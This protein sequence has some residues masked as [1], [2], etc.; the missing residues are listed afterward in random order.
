MKRLGLMMSLGAEAPSV[1]AIRKRLGGRDASEP[2]VGRVVTFDTGVGARHGV[3]LFARAEH[4]EV[5]VDA[6]VVRSVPRAAAHDADT[7]ALTEELCA[8]ALD[9]RAFAEMEEG[10]QVVFTTEHG[11]AEGVLAEKCRFGAIVAR[12]DGRAVG[13]GFRRLASPSAKLTS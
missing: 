7:D 6:G 8:V 5:Y 1:E 3:V 4:L 9:A 10:Q 11:P 13:V 12:P 2:G